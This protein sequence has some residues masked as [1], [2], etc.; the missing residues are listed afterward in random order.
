M[1]QAAYEI[2]DLPDASAALKCEG[3]EELFEY[4]DE[5]PGLRAFISGRL[6]TGALDQFLVDFAFGDPLSVP[7]RTIQVAQVGPV[8]AVAP[9]SLFAWKVHAL[10]QFGRYAWRPKDVYDLYV[11]WTEGRLNTRV[12]PEAIDLAFSSRD[13][14]LDELDN[15]RTDDDWGLAGFETERWDAFATAYGV[16]M[17]FQSLRMHVRAALDQLL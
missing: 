12:L 14:T 15:F 10:V 5:F 9:E 13:T 11:L 8:L 17:S 4:T 1:S 16:T 2:V 6:S 3:T 7:P